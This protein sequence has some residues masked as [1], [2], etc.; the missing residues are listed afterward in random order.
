MILS[1]KTD[2]L[3]FKT[4]GFL[5]HSYDLTITNHGFLQLKHSSPVSKN[6]LCLPII[7]HHHHPFLFSSLFLLTLLQ[8]S[9][10]RAKHVEHKILWWRLSVEP[11]HRTHREQ[12]PCPCKWQQYWSSHLQQTGAS[13]GLWDG[14]AHRLHYP[15]LLHHELSQHIHQWRWRW[16]C[17][18]PRRQ[19]IVHPSGISWRSNRPIQFGFLFEFLLEFHRESTCCRWIWQLHERMGSKCRSYWDQCQ[20]DCFQ[21]QPDMAQ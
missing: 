8:F 10:V 19:W 15:L 9:T 14:K 6:P 11:N 3:S 21:G 5:N 17:L 1:H 20:F 13:L 4:H 7:Y 16:S 18:L 2:K 12:R